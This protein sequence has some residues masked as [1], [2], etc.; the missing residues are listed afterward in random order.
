MTTSVKYDPPLRRKTV[1]EVRDALVSFV[2]LLEGTET[3][4][5]TPTFTEKTTADLTIQSAAVSAAALTIDG[6]AVAAGKAGTAKL[7]GGVAG[8]VY[9]ITVSCGTSAGNTVV[10]PIHLQVIAD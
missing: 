2:G 9:E 10:S 5:G 7:S 6:A 8:R 4:T 3:L 1:S